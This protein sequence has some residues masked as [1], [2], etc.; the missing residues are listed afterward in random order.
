MATLVVAV[1]RRTSMACNFHRREQVTGV[2][3]E[4]LRAAEEACSDL[5]RRPACDGPVSRLTLTP[6]AGSRSSPSR[7]Q[8]CATVGE[9]AVCRP[10]ILHPGQPAASSRTSLAQWRWQCPV[11]GAAAA[12]AETLAVSTARCRP[13]VDC[14][15]PS[16][17]LRAP[18]VRSTTGA[19][20]QRATPVA[21]GRWEGPRR[22]C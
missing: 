11:L 14:A 6:V 4:R 22:A 9:L 19:L 2:L 8:I 13:Q 1:V 20:V 16:C 12:P 10:R 18:H 7:R 21:E 5:K 15:E 3:A 17:Q